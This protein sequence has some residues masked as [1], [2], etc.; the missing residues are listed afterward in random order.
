MTC[1]V[2]LDPGR[3][4]AAAA[5][6]EDGASLTLCRFSLA[7]D[8]DVWAWLRESQNIYGGIGAIALEKVNAMPGGEGRRMGATSAMS[9][10][11]SVGLLRGLLIALGRPWEEPLP[12][13]W[14]KA[15]GVSPPAGIPYQQRKKRLKMHAQ[16]M[17]PDMTITADIADALLLAEYARRLAAQRRGS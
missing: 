11:A 14:Q 10:G 9:F 13:Q 5:V 1:Y 4:G 7:T 8:A 3:T 16:R 2:G 12:V 17:F 6:D 15:L